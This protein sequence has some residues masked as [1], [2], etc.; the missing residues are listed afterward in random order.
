[1]NENENKEVL[2]GD[3]SGGA[4]SAGYHHIESFLRCAKEFQYAQVRGIHEPR[5]QVP[6]HFAVGQLF[7]AGRAR[8]FSLRHALG[9]DAWAK[10]QDAVKAAAVENKLPV[11]LNAEQRALALLNEYVDF[12]SKRPKPD[13]VAAEYFIGPSEL[14]PG[15]PT[16]ARTA[17]LDDV[18]HYPESGGKLALGESKTTSTDV[19]DTINQYTL[20]GQ[21]LLQIALWKMAPQGEAMHG[22]VAGVVLDVVKKPYGKDRCKFAREFIPVNDRVVAWFVKNLQRSLREASQITWDTDAPRNIS[23]CTRMV[24]RMRAPCPYRELCRFGRS[25]SVKYVL[26]DGKSLLTW[27]PKPG[28][29]VPPW[30]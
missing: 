29:T 23:A 7:H 1:M 25:A 11:S 21:P 17:R 13:P 26:R 27:K 6:D 9:A 30:E 16:S 3:A 12:W 2:L 8:W 10:I 5:A 4:T 28:E 14:V 18:S 19:G 20:H 15:D 22:P 24:G